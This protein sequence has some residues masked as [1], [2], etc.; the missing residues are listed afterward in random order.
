MST[1]MDFL[2][3]WYVADAPRPDD[4]CDPDAA[5]ARLGACSGDSC[6]QGRAQCRTPQACQV[7]EL[8]DDGMGL[9]YGLAVTL[10]VTFGCILAGWALATWLR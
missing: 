6:R 5:P 10:G 8:D 3:S 9:F 4:E 7:P 1:P 2:P